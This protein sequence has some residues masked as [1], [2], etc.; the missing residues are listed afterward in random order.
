MVIVMVVVMMMMVIVASIERDERSRTRSRLPHEEEHHFCLTQLQQHHIL[1][2]QDWPPFLHQQEGLMT[3]IAYFFA[4]LLIEGL[5]CE[6]FS[7]CIQLFVV[8]V[9]IN[10]FV[11]W[12]PA[13]LWKWVFKAHFIERVDLMVDF[14]LNRKSSAGSRL[15]PTLWTTWHFNK[16]KGLLLQNVENYNDGDD[17]DDDD[18]NNSRTKLHPPHHVLIHKH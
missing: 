18:T 4:L 1:Q 2:D 8:V 7:T 17:D 9:Q 14:I 16:E 3:L 11:W 15:T 6:R 5:S 12:M 13:A 10:C